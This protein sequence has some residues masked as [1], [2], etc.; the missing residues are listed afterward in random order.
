MFF[1]YY[2]T[3]ADLS[4]HLILDTAHLRYKH[5][6]LM[7]CNCI[8]GAMGA[9]LLDTNSQTCLLDA[10]S[11]YDRWYLWL[12]S[13]LSWLLGNYLF[14]ATLLVVGHHTESIATAWRRDGTV[15]H[16]PTTL[17]LCE[18]PTDFEA[19]I[20]LANRPHARL[21]LFVI[22]TNWHNT[23]SPISRSIECA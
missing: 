6:I 22:S 13:S 12:F 17:R 5:D 10:M 20:D 15:K 19:S 3:V 7:W 18:V 21:E 8:R 4:S 16:W 11:Q 9:I 23:L 1:N 2:Q 14:I